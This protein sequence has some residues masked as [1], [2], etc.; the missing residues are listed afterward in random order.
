MQSSGRARSKRRRFLILRET[1]RTDR[2]HK[3]HLGGGAA[4][5]VGWYRK[6]RKVRTAACTTR[7]CRREKEAAFVAGSGGPDATK[8]MGVVCVAP[9]LWGKVGFWWACLARVSWYFC[10]S[11]RRFG[12]KA[13]ST[14]LRHFLFRLKRHSTRMEWKREAFCVEILNEVQLRQTYDEMCYGCSG[15]VRLGAR[16]NKRRDSVESLQ[17]GS[18]L[19]AECLVR[20]RTSE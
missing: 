17:T 12:R 8:C 2:S 6:R 4:E 3:S 5:C 1:Q 13:R 16:R 7:G 10:V 20:R 9:S 18:R 15:Y 19:V 11:R 14:A